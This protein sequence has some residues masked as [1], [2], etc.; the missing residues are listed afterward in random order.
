MASIK[1]TNGFHPVTV[2]V[3]NAL[4][5]TVLSAE[6]EIIAAFVDIRWYGP[7]H[8]SANE[9]VEVI[10]IMAEAIEDTTGEERTAVIARLD[11]RIERSFKAQVKASEKHYARLGL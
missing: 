11:N 2:R 4:A 5:R 7:E 9:W 1:L 6:R 10:E 3:H 8:P